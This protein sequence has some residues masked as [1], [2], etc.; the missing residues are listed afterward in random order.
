MFVAGCSQIFT[1]WADELMAEVPNGM[2]TKAG[3]AQGAW[4]DPNQIFYHGAYDLAE[5]EALLIEFVPP[6]VIT[7]TF[8]STIVGW[9]ASIIG[10]CR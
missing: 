2:H 7:G 4:G 9:R 8:R 3:P 1:D 10:G 6:S 5:G